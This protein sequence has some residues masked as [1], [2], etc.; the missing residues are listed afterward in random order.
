MNRLHES[1]YRSSSLRSHAS[2]LRSHASSL[3][4]HFIGPSKPHLDRCR[5]LRC[6]PPELPF[7]DNRK[8]I[9]LINEWRDDPPAGYDIGSI[10][11]P[12]LAANLLAVYP[13]LLVSGTWSDELTVYDERL[14]SLDETFSSHLV[15]TRFLI[16]LGVNARR[17]K[18]R[19]MEGDDATLQLARS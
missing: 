12:D 13:K 17:F 16:R 18:L 6:D 2:S 5:W 1:E 9:E 3:L 7:P 15:L 10:F 4:N 19:I 11:R 8:S 14:T